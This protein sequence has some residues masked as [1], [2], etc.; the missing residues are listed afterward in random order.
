[1]G[2]CSAAAVA[3]AAEEKAPT[4]PRDAI[5]TLLAVK[6][7]LSKHAAIPASKSNCND[8]LTPHV[9]AGSNE[10]VSVKSGWPALDHD[11]LD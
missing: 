4:A 10:F 1:M 3:F 8:D 2:A 7:D 9:V 6:L 11:E 5:A